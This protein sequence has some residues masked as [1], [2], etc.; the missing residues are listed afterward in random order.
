MIRILFCLL[1]LIFVSCSKEIVLKDAGFEKSFKVAKKYYEK[2]NY[3]KTIETLDI[4]LLNYTG[5]DN[6]DSAQYLLGETHFLM[7]EYL[8]ASYEYRRLYDNFP[9]SGLAEQSLYKSAESYFNLA[10]ESSLD[11]KE[12]NS[13][14]TKFEIFLD[15]FPNGANADSSKSKIMTLRTRLAKKE[16]DT[17]LL[18]IKLDEI[19]SAKIYLL[20]LIDTYYDTKYYKPALKELSTLFTKFKDEEKSNFYLEKYNSLK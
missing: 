18:Y 8:N 6:I 2:K 15:K 17:A 19:K 5:S 3:L 12:T 11:Q 10:P 16:F 20:N 14:I 9:K 4:I 1:S 13:A 7:K